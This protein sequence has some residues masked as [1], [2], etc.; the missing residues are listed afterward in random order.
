MTL[1][2]PLQMLMLVRCIFRIFQTKQIKFNI[3]ALEAGATHVDVSVI[4]IG[5]RNGITPLGGL[6]AR[7]YTS[8]KEYVKNKFNLTKIREIENIVA[9]AVGVAIPFNNCITGY[10]AF[11]HKAGIHANAVLRNPST[12]ECLNALDFGLTRRVIIGHHLTGWHGVK[13]RIVEIG[14][15]LCDSDAKAIT[16]K[17]KKLADFRSLSIDEVDGLLRSYQRA[18][19]RG[20]HTAFLNNIL[21][22]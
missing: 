10:S 2:V 9:E 6:L 11:T 5:E 1:D 14:L 7:I 15:D 8:N 18:K 21:I 12:Y 19:I 20:E 16:V 17:I 13:N 3:L 22:R 4:G